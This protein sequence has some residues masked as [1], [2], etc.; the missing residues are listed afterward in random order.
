[1][2]KTKKRRDFVKEA[3]EFYKKHQ[4]PSPLTMAETESWD[5]D[6]QNAKAIREY[7]K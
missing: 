7:K 4:G 5:Q 1:M 2:D 3:Y 6:V